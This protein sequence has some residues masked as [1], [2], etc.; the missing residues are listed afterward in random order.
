MPPPPRPLQWLPTLWSTEWP[1][2]LCRDTPR[3]W[4]GTAMVAVWLLWRPCSC[5]TQRRPSCPRSTRCSASGSVPLP[6]RAASWEQL[7]A[8]TSPQSSTTM[9]CC[10]G[11]RWD[12][13]RGCSRLHTRTTGKLRTFRMPVG[14]GREI[15]PCTHTR[16]STPLRARALSLG[17]SGH[18]TPLLTHLHITCLHVTGLIFTALIPI[19]AHARTRAHPHPRARAQ[20]CERPRVQRGFDHGG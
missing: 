19:H 3:W 18:Q 17:A 6:L 11:C 4:S 12:R 2:W 14:N 5:A 15:A 9:T 10:Q 1:R 20:V 7:P 16:S 13:P 8:L